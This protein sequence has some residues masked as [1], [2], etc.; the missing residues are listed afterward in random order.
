MLNLVLA[1]AAALIWG[2][3]FTWYFYGDVRRGWTA[4]RTRWT[5]PDY[6]E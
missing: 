6:K 2:G 3:A 1:I 5:R 4:Y